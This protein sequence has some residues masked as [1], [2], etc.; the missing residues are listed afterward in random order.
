M[1]DLI[2]TKTKS[3]SK[4]VVNAEGKE[5]NDPEQISNLFNSY[6]VN[7]GPNL[8]A[9]INATRG[10]F[11]QYLNEPFHKSLF[12][13]PTNQHEILKIVQALKPSAST[14]YDGISVKLLK[15]IIHFIVD[16]LLYIFNLSITSG[17]CPDSLK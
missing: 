6:F 17:A 11:T 7:I 8:A 5:I 15:K 10:D 4:T 2:G 14:G 12:L 3:T 13:R 1:K 16:P 9:K